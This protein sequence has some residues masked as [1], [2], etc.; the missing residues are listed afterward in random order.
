M[1]TIMIRCP[2]T[3]K[4]ISTGIGM[5]D[6]AFATATLS[7]NSVKCPKCKQVHVWDKDAF[8]R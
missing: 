7:N 8:L 6:A 3:G 2:V 5:S 1:T 4:E